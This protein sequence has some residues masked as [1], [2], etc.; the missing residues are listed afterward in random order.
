[1]KHTLSN[2]QN[3]PKYDDDWQAIC[4][5]QDIKPSNMNPKLTPEKNEAPLSI[6]QVLFSS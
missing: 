3:K 4:K 2:A 6:S 5:S 1:M